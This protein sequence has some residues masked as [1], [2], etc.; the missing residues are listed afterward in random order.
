MGVSS[1][2]DKAVQ[3]LLAGNVALSAAVTGIYVGI[4]PQAADSGDASAFPY[5]VISDTDLVDYHTATESGFDITM[6]IVTVS[7]SPGRKECREIQD[8]IFEALHRKQSSL[9]VTGYSVLLIDREGSTVN[10]ATDP[11][12]SWNGECEYRAIITR[13]AAD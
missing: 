5:V 6:T 11:D 7:R 8:L 10:E 9:S 4:A 2:W 3:N 1:D 13:N 12:G